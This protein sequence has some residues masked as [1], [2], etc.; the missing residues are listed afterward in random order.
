MDKHNGMYLNN[1]ILFSHKKEKKFW[2]VFQ[3]GELLKILY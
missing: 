2:N 1:E 3:Y